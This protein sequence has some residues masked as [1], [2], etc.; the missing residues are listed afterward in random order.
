VRRVPLGSFVSYA[1]TRL[2]SDEPRHSRLALVL[3]LDWTDAHAGDEPTSRPAVE[4]VEKMLEGMTGKPL[5]GPG[6]SG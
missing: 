2:E 4:W 5:P 1:V 6:A 3:A